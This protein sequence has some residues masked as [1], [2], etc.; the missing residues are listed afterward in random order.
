MEFRFGEYF[1]TLKALPVVR[2]HMG[3][4]G[5]QMLYDR[6]TDTVYI[7]SFGSTDYT[8]GSVRTMIKILSYAE[9]IGE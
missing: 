8:A 5:T 2:G 6:N 4:L 7:S 3:V 9:R 1:P